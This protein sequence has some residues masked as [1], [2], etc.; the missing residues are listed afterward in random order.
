MKPR[1]IKFFLLDR[2]SKSIVL[3][4]RTDIRLFWDSTISWRELC[5]AWSNAVSNFSSKDLKRISFSDSLL[6]INESLSSLLKLLYLS[7]F[8][9]VLSPMLSLFLFS[10]CFSPFDTQSK[11]LTALQ[12]KTLTALNAKHHQLTPYTKHGYILFT[13]LILTTK[14]YI[15]GI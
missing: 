10:L 5:L 12:S 11:T 1:N 15:K 8:S 7:K 13:Y 4:S 14:L 9:P 2:A 6:S 3:Y